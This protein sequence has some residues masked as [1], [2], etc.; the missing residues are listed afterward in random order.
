MN[1]IDLTLEEWKKKYPEFRSLDNKELFLLLNTYDYYREGDEEDVDPDRLLD[2]YRQGSKFP[3]LIND[4]NSDDT[5]IVAVIAKYESDTTDSTKADKAYL[6]EL[7]E[8]IMDAGQ[9]LAILLEKPQEET[10]SGLA[11]TMESAKEVTLNDQSARL[12]V[13]VTRKLNPA[14]K[15]SI[16]N[17]FS[18]AYPNLDLALYS[19]QDVE[20]Q[21]DMV[22]NNKLYVEEGM[23]KLDQA[24]NFLEYEDSC[25][26]NI[27]AQSLQDLYTLRRNGLLGM[28]LRFYVKSRPIDTALEKSAQEH[29]EQFWYKNNG[30]VIV[31]DSYALDGDELKLKNFSIINGGQTTNRIGNMEIKDDFFLP[32]KVIERPDDESGEFIKEVAVATNS[33]KPIKQEDL[34]AHDPNQLELGRRLKSLGVYYKLKR[35]STVDSRYLEPYQ[36]LDIKTAG[37]YGMASILQKPGTARN[38]Q[39]KIFE[40]DFSPY[41]FG[42]NAPAGYIADSAKIIY[43]YSNF[44]KHELKK[45]SFHSE[46][47]LPIFKNGSLWQLASIGLI[48]KMLNGVVNY[49]NDIRPYMKDKDTLKK[50]LRRTDGVKDRIIHSHFDDEEKRFYEL[51]IEIGREILADRY[52]FQKAVDEAKGKDL[53]VSNFLKNDNNYYDQIIKRLGLLVADNHTR[54]SQISH[55]LLAKGD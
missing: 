39:K 42:P 8:Q 3:V 17:K 1:R 32:C 11:R 22:T 13:F 48:S 44:L 29:P 49:D 45:V 34:N 23:L 37:K 2:L 50:N 43:Y 30:I 25:I 5:D 7:R 40:E 15:K 6:K 53:N 12:A 28:N 20:S 47:E 21:L 9:N 31:C 26:V 35:G 4:V 33:Q 19:L 27:S 52:E 16:E 54:L 10:D 18:Q 36:T 46:C 14:S 41:I 51:F 55:Q 24:H 38:C